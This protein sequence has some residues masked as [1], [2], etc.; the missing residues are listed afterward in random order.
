M[1]HRVIAY[2]RKIKFKATVT[3]ASECRLW[4]AVNRKASRLRKQLLCNKTYEQ[5]AYCGPWRCVR[6]LWDWRRGSTYVRG[7]QSRGI[8]SAPEVH[9]WYAFRMLIQKAMHRKAV[10]WLM[11]SVTISSNRGEQPRQRTSREF[12][13]GPIWAHVGIYPL[14]MFPHSN[15]IFS[16][17]LHCEAVQ[18]KTNHQLFQHSTNTHFKHILVLFV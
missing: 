7:R 1:T 12:E 15:N 5:R 17:M 10:R 6:R 9:S 3:F 11:L 2:M 14:N 18:K 16:S 13:P 8:A 4:N